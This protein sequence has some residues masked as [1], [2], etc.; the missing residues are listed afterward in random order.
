TT[1]PRPSFYDRIRAFNQYYN[2][3]EASDS[4]FYARKLESASESSVMVNGQKLLMFGSN[5]YL[6][7]T[8][9][10]KVKEAALKAIEKYGVGAG[11]VR[12]LGGSFELHEEL[13]CRLAEFKGPQAAIAFSSGYVSNLATISAF[14]HKEHD[15]VIM[16]E[17]IHA[18]L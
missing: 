12:M 1:D 5:N 3:L 15:I 11:S 7:M 17:K 8:T 10:P 9:H 6:G 14:L 18:S 13:E 4:Y 2:D 16:D